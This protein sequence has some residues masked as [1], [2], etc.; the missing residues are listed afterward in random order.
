MESSQLI[1]DASV[2]AKWF[3]RDEE[4]LTTADAV[5][6]DWEAGRWSLSAP[7]HLPFEVGNAILRAKRQSRLAERTA[8][9]ALAAFARLTEEISFQPPHLVVG[10]G[11]QLT[12]ALG[13]SFFDA[14]YLHVARLMGASLITADAAFYRQTASQADVIWLGDYA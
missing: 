4:L 14:C 6:T 2:V 9:E 5:R 10:G 11:T 8:L 1:L 3:L 13:V 12:D 7:G